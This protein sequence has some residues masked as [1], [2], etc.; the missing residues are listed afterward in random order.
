MGNQIPAMPGE[1]RKGSLQ[2]ATLSVCAN[3]LSLA[4]KNKGPEQMLR[5]FVS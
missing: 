1:T 4:R 2:K 3:A 5:A